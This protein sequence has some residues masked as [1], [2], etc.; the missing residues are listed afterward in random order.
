MTMATRK[1]AKKK[2]AP[3]MKMEECKPKCNTMGCSGGCGG[4]FY[5]LGVLGAAV[6]YIAAASGF[7]AG[8]L[9]FLKACVWPT[10]LVYELLKFLGA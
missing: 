8:V 7:W 1:R 2:A 5:G 4:A 6:Y 3:A 9:G 10:F